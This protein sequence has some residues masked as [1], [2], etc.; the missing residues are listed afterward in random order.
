MIGSSTLL[1]EST[2]LQWDWDSFDLMPSA[3]LHHPRH[4]VL[5]QVPHARD[6]DL[7]VVLYQDVGLR[8]R[9]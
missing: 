4:L 8:G 1:M 6:T 7:L 9:R 5:L 3:S 2:V